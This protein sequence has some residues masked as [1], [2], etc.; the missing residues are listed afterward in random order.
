MID[1][2]TFEGWQK[3]AKADNYAYL[4][5]PTGNDPAAYEKSGKDY[6]DLIMSRVKSKG[7]IMDYGC[8]N[9]R[10]L[11]H[12]RE[13][14]VGIDIV[15]EAAA[16]V[17][18]FTPDAYKGKVDVIYSVNVLIHNTYA[19]GKAI[20]RWMHGRLKKGG[21]LLLQMPIYDKAKEPANYLDVGVWTKDMLIEATEGFRLDEC[22]TNPGEFTFEAIGLYHFDFHTLTKL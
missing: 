21:M 16:M 9:G 3:A 18:G 10:I 22:K 7:I 11:R 20:I 4:I 15:P 8:G 19:S 13:P 14:K 12:I 5:H 2:Q 6:A 1:Q 17:G